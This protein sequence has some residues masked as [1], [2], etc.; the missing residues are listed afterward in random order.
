MLDSFGFGITSLIC[1]FGHATPSLLSKI[2]KIIF[3][4]C[5]KTYLFEPWGWLCTY[6]LFTNWYF[7]IKT[8]WFQRSKFSKVNKIIYNSISDTCLIVF[9]P[10]LPIK[11]SVFEQ[12]TSFKLH[13]VS[14]KQ[15]ESGSIHSL[16]LAAWRHRKSMLN[17]PTKFKLI[18][19]RQHMSLI[20]HRNSMMYGDICHS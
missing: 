6:Y 10:K 3:I 15:I 12:K 7:V 11:W 14:G 1:S 18:K 13:K 17:K 16:I 4:L 19:L 5:C 8:V 9:V 20:V 2:I